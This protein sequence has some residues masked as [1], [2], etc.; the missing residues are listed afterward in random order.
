MLIGLKVKAAVCNGIE[1]NLLDNL[2]GLSIKGQIREL[3]I[4]YPC[5][6][7]LIERSTGRVIMNKSTDQF[8]NFEFDHLKATKFTIIAHHPLNTFNAVI[9]D[10]VVPK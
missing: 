10:L 9:A 5:D 8:G 3:N 1:S 6:V 2:K 7:R 4:P